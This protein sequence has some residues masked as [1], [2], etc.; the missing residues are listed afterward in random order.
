VKRTFFATLTVLLT[1]TWSLAAYGADTDTGETPEIQFSTDAAKDLRDETDDLATPVKIYEYLLNNADHALY[2]GS[3][4][5]S[6]NS[7]LGLRGNDVD[8][9]ST[10]IAMYRYRGYHARYAVGTVQVD[11]SRVI[12]WLGVKNL[13]LAVS[14]MKDQGIQNVTLAADRSY[15]QFEHVWVEVLLP[16]GNYRGSGVDAANGTCS[17]STNCHWVALDPSFKQ[18]QYNDQG[19]DPYS[20]LQFDYTSYYNAIKNSDSMRTDKNPLEIYEE[21]VLSYLQTNYPGKTLEDVAYTGDI[22]TG[23]LDSSRVT[24]LHSGGHAAQGQFGSRP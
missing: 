12:N 6:I 1:L 2:H 15:V 20:S 9:A 16:Y 19:I 3:R 5:G 23:E 7:F 13:D 17:A 14:I 24:R 21:Q 8:L 11:A 10:M 4:S 22:N 18:K